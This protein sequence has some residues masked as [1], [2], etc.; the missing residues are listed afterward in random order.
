MLSLSKYEG[1]PHTPPL[2]R[3]L[4]SDAVADLAEGRLDDRMGIGEG[5]SVRRGKRTTAE[6]CSWC[7]LP[8]PLGNP[9]QQVRRFD[10]T[11]EIVSLAQVATEIFQPL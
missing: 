7:P 3:S 10:W 8:G 9:G 5:W 1:L 11:A 2:M 6:N 4:V